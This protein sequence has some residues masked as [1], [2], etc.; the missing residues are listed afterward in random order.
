MVLT[1]P[2]N[3]ARVVALLA[4][5]V[6][7]ASLVGAP[8]SAAPSS[9]PKP[10]PVAAASTV[11]PPAP[12]APKRTTGLAP[13]IPNQNG[14]CNFNELCLWYFF[15]FAGSMSDFAFTTPH[16]G[17]AT[18]LSAG[19]GQ[20]AHVTNNSESFYDTD[21]T[22]AVN[23]CVNDN[24]VGPCMLIQPGQYGNF[25][26]PFYDNVESFNFTFLG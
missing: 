18:F 4:T 3:I 26:Y 24:L 13:A 14:V 9:H 19:T 7:S 21:S 15:N 6:L 23:A 8:A 25:P 1:N 2:R 17:G 22:Y 11:R 10:G 16:I 12:V 20:G 5:T